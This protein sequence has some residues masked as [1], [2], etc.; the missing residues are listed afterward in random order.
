MKKILLKLKDNKIPIFIGQNTIKNISFGG[1]IKSKDIV[2]VINR[3]LA[4]YYLNSLKKTLGKFNTKFCIIPD[5]EKY[6]N[7]LTLGKIH[8]FL[9]KEKF[10]RHCTIIAFGGGVIGDLAGFAADTFLRGVNLI[11]IPTTLL[12]QVDSSIGGKTGINH[13]LGKNLIGSFKHPSLIIID[14]NYLK[15]L[16]MKE[17][18]SGLAEVIKYGIIGKKSFLSW[19]NKNAD[20]ILNKDIDALLKLITISVQEKVAVVQKD[21]KESN[22]RALLNFGHTIGHAV[23]SAKN[24]KGIL[25]GEAVSIGMIFASAASVEN[26]GLDINE[27]NLIEDTLKKLGLPISIPKDIKTTKIMSHLAFDKKKKDGK[28]NFILIKSI[29]S[30]YISNSLENEYISKLIKVFQS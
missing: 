1:F 2:V 26:A 9:I 8:N 6:K 19:I 12:S 11:H 7:I 24:Y 29:G 25:H 4:K 27:F 18:V 20:L 17:F 16:P 21:E 14:I 5:G 3:T 28:S 13:A 15:T 10:D 30:S 22:I 23:E